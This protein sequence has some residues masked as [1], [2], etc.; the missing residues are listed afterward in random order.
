MIPLRLRAEIDPSI[1]PFVVR[2]NADWKPDAFA[3]DAFLNSVDDGGLSFETN[4]GS[5]AIHGLEMAE[6]DGDVLLVLPERK[7]AHRIIRAGSKHNTLLVT[8]RCDQLCVMCSQPPKEHHADFFGFFETAVQLAPPDC[9]IG[10]SGGEP[11][12]YKE[13]LFTFLERSLTSRPDLSFHILSNGQHF[14][15]TDIPR[16]RA[17]S[18]DKVQWGIPLYSHKSSTHDTIVAKEGAF[19]RLMKSFVHLLHAGARIELR[20]VVLKSNV[21]DLD[22]LA[23]FVASHLPFISHWSI[24]QL[25][26]IGY[27]R[28]NWADIFFDHSLDF[29]QIGT[30]LDIALSRGIRPLLFNF[31]LCTV[32]TDYRQFAPSTISDWKQRFLDVCSSCVLRSKCSGFFEWYDEKNGFGRVGQ[33]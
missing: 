13:Q 6:L 23:S 3:D 4:R 14:E 7:I 16:L 30:A 20:T 5:L 29:G 27:A 22:G 18:P 33:L 28:K 26:R 21:S 17:L 32:P 1:A 31:P 12:L 24:M 2:L 9:V 8:E 11:T 19:N 10:I 25:E 15:A